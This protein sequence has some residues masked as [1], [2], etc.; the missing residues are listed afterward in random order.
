MLRALTARLHVV[1]RTNLVGIYLYG[2]LTQRAFDRKR[3]DVDCI[4]VVR[5]DLSDA[6]FRKLA[7][8]LEREAASDPW[9]SR[10][11]MHMLLR[12]TLLSPDKRGCLYQFGVLKRSGS[13]G[14]PIIWANVL[15]TGI[16]LSGPAAASFL[17]AIAA[18]TFFQALVREVGYLRAEIADPASEWRDVPFYRSYAILTLCRILYSARKGG[19]V[20]KP[21]A[22][23]W[24][25]RALPIEWHSLVGRALD[26]DRGKGPRLPL[27]RIAQFIAFVDAQLRAPDGGRRA[28]KRQSARGFPV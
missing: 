9:V 27:P 3:S 14:N 26:R 17:P 16:T 20:S 5:R 25:G 21:R 13:D 1:L 2:S 23:R 10:L 28:E 8:W 15:A 24:A 18:E 4:V 12:D 22:A 7:A 6:Q 19:V 11:Q